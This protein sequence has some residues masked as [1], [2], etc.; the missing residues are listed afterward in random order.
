MDNFECKECDK[1]FNSA[2]ALN[3]HNLAKHPKTDTPKFKIK[4]KHIYFFIF[5]CIV[6]ALGFW[7]YHSA[8]SP[9]KYDNF[10]KCLTAE[11]FIMAGTEW[12]SNCQD[13]KGLFGKSFK[14][15]NYKN[16]GTNEEWC[17][18]NGINRYPTWIL[19]DGT[20]R[21]GNQELSS[22]QQTSSN[23]NLP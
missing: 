3:A 15:I 10:A 22:L 2:D 9:G 16:C 17:S 13:Q 8:T 14:Y 20:K 7:I 5:I 21:Q 6:F 4:K 12:C 18:A 1:K 23:C 19:P 11:G